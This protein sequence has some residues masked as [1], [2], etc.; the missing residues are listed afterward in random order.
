LEKLEPFGFRPGRNDSFAFLGGQFID[1][2]SSCDSW[3][4]AIEIDVTA[5]NER[6]QIL[7]LSTNN[8]SEGFRGF[9]LTP[10]EDMND[11]TEPSEANP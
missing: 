10:I 1:L 7:G 6:G 8:D 11:K 2:R 5:I 3:P 9:L 4:K